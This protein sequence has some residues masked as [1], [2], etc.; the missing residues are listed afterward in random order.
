MQR[1]PCTLLASGKTRFRHCKRRKKKHKLIAIK[2][3]TTSTRAACCEG[4][5]CRAGGAASSRAP[6]LHFPT[7]VT[8]SCSCCRGPARDG[9]AGMGLRPPALTQLHGLRGGS[10]STA[11]AVRDHPTS[12]LR[13]HGRLCKQHE[14]QPG[15]GAVLRCSEPAALPFQ[16]V[17]VSPFFL[18][19]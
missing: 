4:A 3:H 6:A 15:F 2:N 13:G 17:L 14:W 19:G 9:A 16:A 5:G 7:P 8:C 18:A 1:F 10:G 12:A 11:P